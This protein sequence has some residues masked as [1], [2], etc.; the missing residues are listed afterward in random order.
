M[1]QIAMNSARKEVICVIIQLSPTNIVQVLRIAASGSWRCDRLDQSR[2]LLTRMR[3]VGTDNECQGGYDAL[4]L[5][6]KRWRIA[7]QVFTVS[8]AVLPA[9]SGHSQTAE[10]LNGVLTFHSDEDHFSGNV[11][12]FREGRVVG[13]ESRGLANQEWKIPNAA[14]TRFAIGSVTKQFTAA[15]ILLLQEQGRLKTSDPVALYYKQAPAAWKNITI[16]QLLLHT[17]GIPE[18]LFRN[19]SVGF[20][21]G[22]HSPEEV[23]QAAA[24][25]PLKTPPGTV[26][27]YNNVEYVL[28]G[29][30]VERVSGD[31]YSIFLSKHI[32]EPLGMLDTGVGWL[33]TIIP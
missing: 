24:Q 8:L 9:K 6:F 26:T 19:D 32:F 27:A 14:N 31:S 28:L 25:K 10:Q 20:E 11:V 22:L 4:M 29:L 33:P 17:S 3:L 30:I 7:L 12:V 23:V 2:P 1:A 18:E 13:N 5:H 16:R 21:R 15:A